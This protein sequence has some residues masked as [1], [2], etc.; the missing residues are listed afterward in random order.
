M[1]FSAPPYDEIA[2]ARLAETFAAEHLA[3]YGHAFAG[4]FPV[5]IVNLRLTGTL[6]GDEPPDLRMR[7]QIA[8]VASRRSCYFG[9]THGV[10]DTLVIDRERLGESP[11]QGPIVIEEYEGTVVVPPDCLASRDGYGNIVIELPGSPSPASQA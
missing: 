7:P 10:V 6:L 5:E 8:G 3:R 9:P 4:R 2:V 11:Q 1:P